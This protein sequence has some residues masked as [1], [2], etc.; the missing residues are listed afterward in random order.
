MRVSES[1]RVSECQVSEHAPESTLGVTTP[2]PSDKRIAGCN[3]ARSAQKQESESRRQE[4][5]RSRDKNQALGP[6]LES[7]LQQSV[8]QSEDL[9][10]D[11]NF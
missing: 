11:T 3:Q 8:S 7:E 4:S 9:R 6:A 1:E 2:G 5:D 10:L